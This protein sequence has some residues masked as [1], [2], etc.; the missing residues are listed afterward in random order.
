VSATHGT[1]PGW[2]AFNGR[3]YPKRNSITKAH[4]QV[5]GPLGSKTLYF[6]SMKRLWQ[7]LF[8]ALAFVSLLILVAAI[9]AGILSLS[10]R[11]RWTY[12]TV[13]SIN[14]GQGN[15]REKWLVEFA[16]G[17]MLLNHVYQTINL[18][19]AR[20][21]LPNDGQIYHE[22]YPAQALE[23]QS[24]PMSGLAM[25][26]QSLVK[27]SVHGVGRADLGL[28]YWNATA[29]GFS[30]NG[31]VVA[32]P[33]WLIGGVSAVILVLWATKYII[34]RRLHPEPSG[35]CSNCGYDLRATP[36]CC[37]ECGK[38]RLKGEMISN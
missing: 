23:V 9:G 31:F 37:P 22:S 8:G 6:A 3:E 24:F 20:A 21:H 12:Q 18:S 30:Q 25:F 19:F 15:A 38:I 16:S 27:S 33:L 2:Q 4:R 28:F 11:D 13:R 7:L 14:G 5:I 32:L 10:A 1:A 29:V 36:D 17:G 26:M 34:Y 35:L